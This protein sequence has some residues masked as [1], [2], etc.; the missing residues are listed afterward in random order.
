MQG[1]PRRHV[2]HHVCATMLIALALVLLPGV[3]PQQIDCSDPEALG[4]ALQADG[5]W[6]EESCLSLSFSLSCSF[7]LYISL[8]LSLSLS[9]FL[10]FSLFLILSP[11]LFV[12]FAHRRTLMCPCRPKG[13]GT[14]SFIFLSLFLSLIVFIS[15]A[16][17]H[18]VSVFHSLPRS[19]S[20]SRHLFA[21]VSLSL[22]LSPA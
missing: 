6:A 7:S 21:S 19:T 17:T 5:L 10:S 4:R 2:A 3:A 16:N 20:L 11:S 9:L 18:T 8:F 22:P 1:A 14:R 15:R 12:C 13:T